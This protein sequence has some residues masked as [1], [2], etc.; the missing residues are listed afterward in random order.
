MLILG[1]FPDQ[2][3]PRLY[4]QCF[5]LPFHFCP[6]FSL[7]F[8]PAFSKISGNVWS[9]NSPSGNCHRGNIRWRNIHLGH[10]RI[11]YILHASF[12]T[13]TEHKTCWTQIV[14]NSNKI[15]FV[16]GDSEIFND[17]S[18]FSTT[19]CLIWKWEF[20]L[21]KQ[22]LKQPLLH[23]NLI[24]KVCKQVLYKKVK[25]TILCQKHNKCW[26]RQN[27]VHFLLKFII[28]NISH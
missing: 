16:F 20:F 7:F 6:S 21:L 19:F 23:D 9:G 26:R 24:C 14:L 12:N 22:L 15:L 11:P 8:L 4:L 5:F 3:F 18:F 28:W 25:E 27:L 1:Q 2:T 10:V 13:A 17:M